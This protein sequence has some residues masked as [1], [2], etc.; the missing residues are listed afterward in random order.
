[1]SR[2]DQLV[3]SYR[4]HAEIPLKQNV[5]AAE[6]T[7]FVVYSPEEERRL[8]CR[9]AEF[10]IAT[11][12]C[13]LFW[14]EIDLSRAFGMWLDT[15]DDA[16]ERAS[17]LATPSIAEDYARPG[18]HDYM[19]CMIR[20]AVAAA[21]ASEVERTVFALTGLMELY[22]FIHVSEVMDAVGK[23]A[24]GVL[25]VFFPGEREENTYR[26]LGARTG[27]DYLATPITADS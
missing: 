22:D 17:I 27:W 12:D 1:M 9:V 11:R 19:S 16:E 6:R 23:D 7:W 2:I 21:P 4:R 13:G 10:E 8:R 24:R 5:T 18:F 15:F 14:H 20:K 26:F 25:L 3:Q